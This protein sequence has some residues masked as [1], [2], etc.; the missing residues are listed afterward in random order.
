MPYSTSLIGYTGPEGRIGTGA[1]YH[2]DSKYASSL[3]W[4]EVDRR[5]QAKAKRYA[6]E[7]RNIMF[8][9][10]GMNYAVYNPVAPIEQ[11]IA[12]LQKAAGAH[13]KRPGWHA[14]DYYAPK[15]GKDVQDVSVEKAPIYF[16][17]PNNQRVLGATAQDYGNYAYILD[18]KGNVTSKIG[19]GDIN[20]PAYQ[21]N[22]AVN[23]GSGQTV[24][25]ESSVTINNYYG[26]GTETKQR[27]QKG[28]VD[29]LIGSLLNQA[30]NKRKDPITAMMNSMVQQG[31]GYLNPI[32]LY[33]FLK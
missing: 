29:N 6:E 33:Q 28:F 25:P 24:N 21:A 4:E 9:N 20:Y 14:F 18:E 7:G 3:P 27:Q 32:D 15:Q 12:L 13:A 31:S 8:S 11:R 22:Q 16:A 30:L 19:H 1:A 10:T 5:F 26:D 23:P 17:T 2:I